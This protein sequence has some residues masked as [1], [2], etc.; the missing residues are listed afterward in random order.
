MAVAGREMGM[1]GPRLGGKALA[2]GNPFAAGCP[3]DDG[4]GAGGGN[5]AKEVAAPSARPAPANNNRPR[6]EVLRTTANRDSSGYI[7]R[8]G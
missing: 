1:D 5:W 7:G 3:L 4:S 2:P 6:M 8:S